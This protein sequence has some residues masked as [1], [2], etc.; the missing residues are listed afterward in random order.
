MAA[1]NV[2]Q[3]E[4]LYLLYRRNDGLAEDSSFSL[5]IFEVSNPT[6]ATLLNP[7]TNLLN[8]TPVTFDWTQAPASGTNY[9]MRLDIT[10]DQQVTLGDE[11]VDKFYAIQFAYVSGGA[12]ITIMHDTSQPYLGGSAYWDTINA[13]IR[14][15]D[16]GLAIVAIPEPS[17][18]ITL[19]GVAG[20]MMLLRLRRKH[21]AAAA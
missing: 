5:R 20:M 7:G 9:V 3:I 17:T 11:F 1:G 21:T 18:Y 6:A 13:P 15:A 12:A 19:L 8:P 10:G 4:S 16:N 14:G 2:F